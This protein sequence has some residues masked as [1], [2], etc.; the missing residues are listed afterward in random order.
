MQTVFVLQH[1]HLLPDGEEDIKLIGVY[2]SRESALRAVDRLRLMPGFRDLPALV[3]DLGEGP[4]EGSG[5]YLDPYTLDVDGW[6][7]GFETR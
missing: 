5:F 7:E 4:G 1:L 2:S 6:A 3:A